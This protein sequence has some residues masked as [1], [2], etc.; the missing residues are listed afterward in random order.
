MAEK[1]VAFIRTEFQG[2]LVGGGV[3]V[4]KLDLRSRGRGFDSRWGHYQVVTTWMGDCLR[5][6]KLSGYITKPPRSTQPFIPAGWVDLNRVP[7]CLIGAKTGR[8][9]LCR[10]HDRYHR[11]IPYAR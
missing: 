11:V 3:T 7:F 5:T 4:R 9:Y 8:V 2:D 10:V 6:G 1:G